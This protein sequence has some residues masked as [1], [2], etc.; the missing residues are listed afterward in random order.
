MTKLVR[1]LAQAY[2]L[3]ADPQAIELH[4]LGV[5][6]I[7]GDARPES[8]DV[9]GLTVGRHGNR[10]NRVGREIKGAPDGMDRGQ[11]IP[12]FAPADVA[13]S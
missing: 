13:R 10:H 6:Q 1:K 9:I 4:K 7:D 5:V 2:A 8:V 12:A 11:N 3:S